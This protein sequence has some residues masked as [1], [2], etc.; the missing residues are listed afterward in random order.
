MS[1]RSPGRIRPSRSCAPEIPSRLRRRAV[2]WRPR[3]R[4][5]PPEP[6]GERGGACR[7]SSCL[8]PCVG[9]ALCSPVR[10][11]S[12]APLTK[13]S[14]AADSAGCGLLASGLRWL[15]EDAGDVETSIEFRLLG[16]LEAVR[17]GAPVALGGLK[18]R[19][20]LAIL[21]LNANEVVS[22]ERLVDELW[23]AAP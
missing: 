2:A 4:G 5:R 7:R 22:S 18:Q 3:T 10:T 20:L 16:P 23:G 15:Q 9:T 17:D 14:P 1:S 8:P 19:A 21:L 12:R 13:R 6:A 11:S